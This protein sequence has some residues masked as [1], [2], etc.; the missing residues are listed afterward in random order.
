MYQVLVIQL[1]YPLIAKNGSQPATPGRIGDSC[2][3]CATA[4][5]QIVLILLAYDHTFSVHK[6]PYLI[7][8]AIYVSATVHVRIAAQ[9]APDA[10]TLNYLRTCLGWLSQN[11]QTNPGID[12]AKASLTRLMSRMGVVCREDLGSYPYQEELVEHSLSQHPMPRSQPDTLLANS[13]PETSFSRIR[14]PSSRERTNSNFY[15]PFDMDM[16][17]QRLASGQSFGSSPIDT[18]P[19]DNTSPALY[20]P[21]APFGGFEI[22]P[23]D[24]FEGGLLDPAGMSYEPT[25][26]GSA[27][28][29][30][31]FAG[32]TAAGRDIGYPMSWHGND[33][34]AR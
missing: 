18:T 17:L 9:Q 31:P 4:A 16:V 27:E 19:R 8:Y 20:D 14:T 6:A 34:G 2:S 11:Q 13:S 5:K 1:H 15:A 24:T 25:S 10:E 32:L 30:E 28:Q 21:A 23:I 3:I 22:P 7:A 29:L 33:A 12:N 26:V